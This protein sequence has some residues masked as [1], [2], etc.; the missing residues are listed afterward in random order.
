MENWMETS[1]AK[2][3]TE[4]ESKLRTDIQ[5]KFLIPTVR[6]HKIFKNL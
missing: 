4:A 5:L 2:C 6:Y 3:S 1:V